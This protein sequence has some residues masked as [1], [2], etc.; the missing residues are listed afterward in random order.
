VLE[1]IEGIIIKTQDYGETHKIVTIF[2][3]KHG[4][5]SAIARG[6]KKMKSRMAAVTQ[7]FIHGE[8]LIYM[9][10]GLSTI[11]Q[12][13]IV[14]SLRTI[15]EDIVKTAYAAYMTELTDKLVDSHQ[16][17]YYLYDQ[18]V[19]TLRWIAENEEIEIS[20]MMY[21]LKLFKK[22][23]IAPIV[24]QCARCGN[25]DQLVY[26]SIAE[27]GLLC[28]QCLN[29]DDQAIQLPN[30]VAKLL[31]IFANIGLERVGKISVKPEN[32]QLL[33]KLL[34]AYYDQYGGFYLKSR[35]VLNQLKLLD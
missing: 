26:F 13:D 8:F 33:R 18:F 6:A 3:K 19:Q 10:K 31:H 28:N 17:D 23:G 22:G 14:D 25:H 7:P 16:A 21:E 4:K 11:Q 5:F 2:S 12:G 35:R 1:K 24:D 27:G 9:S 34:D 15:R 20:M 30:A 29:F 32:I